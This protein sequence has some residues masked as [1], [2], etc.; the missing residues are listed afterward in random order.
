MGGH[1][2]RQGFKIITAFKGGDETAAAV[3]FGDRTEPSRRLRKILL[4]EV[5]IGERIGSVRVESGRNDDEL[6]RMLAEP[7]Q[8]PVVQEAEEP[9]A[10]A[11]G[12]QRDIHDLAMGSGFPGMPTAGIEWH[13]MG[14]GKEDPVVIPNQVLRPVAVVHVEVHDGHPF[15]SMRGDG[16]PGTDHRIAEQAEPHGLPSFGVMPGRSDGA[17]SVAGFAAGNHVHGPNNRANAAEGGSQ[18]SRP[19]LRVGIQG[20]QALDGY[21][22]TYGVNVVPGMGKMDGII[23]SQRCV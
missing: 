12:R 18:A 3:V 17:K 11:A 4:D 7:G 19:H 2:C 13:L 22:P 6:R 10:V 1:G 16:V 21:R 20:H 23:G 15:H 9:G 14:R 5:D 8:D